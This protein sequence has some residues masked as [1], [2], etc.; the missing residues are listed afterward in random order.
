AV[1]DGLAEHDAGLGRS[2]GHPRQGLGVVRPCGVGIDVETA[3]HAILGV[4]DGVGEAGSR[5]EVPGVSFQV[6][7]VPLESHSL[8]RG[9]TPVRAPGRGAD[10]LD[11][12]GPGGVV[13]LV[14]LGAEWLEP[15]LAGGQVPPGIEVCW[16]DGAAPR[17][18]TVLTLFS[19][20]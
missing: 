19:P 17:F 3:D 12:G 16:Y 15:A 10:V 5:L 11:S 1:G 18:P 4:E 20:P 7:E 8:H 13:P 2:G 14:V 6:G 9:P